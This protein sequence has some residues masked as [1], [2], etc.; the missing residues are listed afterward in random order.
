MVG[1]FK[2]GM[3]EAQQ[4][5]LGATL[6]PATRA[7][8]LTDAVALLPACEST[9]LYNAVEYLQPSASYTADQ[10]QTL[11]D[12]WIGDYDTMQAAY[13]ML[14]PCPGTTAPATPSSSSNVGLAV[15]IGTVVAIGIALA[16]RSSRHR[17]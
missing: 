2:P 9:D 12:G 11:S 14:Q 8:L 15:A 4:R 16:I 10:I 1:Y 6:D 3:T 5:A 7:K 13:D 17:R